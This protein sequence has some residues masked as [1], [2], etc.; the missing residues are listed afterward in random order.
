M[1][2]NRYIQRSIYLGT[3]GALLV[4]VSLSLFFLLVRELD[5]MGRG[6]Y[7]A[8]QVIQYLALNIPGNLVEFMPLA[9]LLGTILS[10]GTLAS[11]SEVI[12]M[13]ASG[14]SLKRMLTA[15]LQASLVLALIGF[16]LADWVVPDSET[17]AR[18]IKNLSRE[19]T[20]ALESSQG[21]WIKDES[22]VVHI[23]AMLPNGYAR[24]VEIFELDQ[25]G[26]LLSTLRAERA[27]PLEQGWELQQ[28]SRSK[29][30]AQGATTQTFERLIYDGNLSREL[31]Q[32]L[33][34]EPRQM[35]ST[36]LYA[37]LGFLDENRVDAHAERLVFWKKIFAPMSVVIMCLLAFPFVL[38]SQRQSSSGQRLLIGILLGLAFVVVER[39]LTQLGIQFQINALLVAAFPNLLFLSVAIYLLI[40]KQSHA[41]GIGLFG[42]GS[43]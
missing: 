34:I 43:Q 37:Y 25:D 9:V 17:G 38:G 10:L 6:G 8:L 2:I 39:L 20:T 21:L 32:V 22:R 12:A 1:I 42:V 11:N 15:V 19:Q 24:E 13:Q 5:D 23:Q 40:R 35:S 7:G 3:L 27:V 36:A 26:K 28:V 30:S 16:L 41:V 31:L 4:L 14:M 18:K 33:T 29:I